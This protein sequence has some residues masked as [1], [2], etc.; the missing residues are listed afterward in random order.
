MEFS[1]NTVLECYIRNL[2][3]EIHKISSEWTPQDFLIFIQ[4]VELDPCT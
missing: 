1:E 4:M 2:N 3:D